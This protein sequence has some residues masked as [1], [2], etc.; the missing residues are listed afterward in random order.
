MIKQ[1]LARLTEQSSTNGRKVNP[2][3]I[4]KLKTRYIS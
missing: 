4:A 1:R 3:E 2:I